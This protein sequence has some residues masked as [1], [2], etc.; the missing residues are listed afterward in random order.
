[1]QHLDEGLLMALLDGELT[2]V[3]QQN[4]ETHLRA[5]SECAGR[6]T[7]LK[8]FMV[9]AD[10]LVADLGEP[11]VI[12][13]RKAR[14]VLARRPPRRRLT[15]RTLAWA[16]SIVGALGLGFAGAQWLGVGTASSDYAVG[17][18]EMLDTASPTVAL[19]P[20]AAASPEVALREE[21]SSQPVGAG[22]A[23]GRGPVEELSE[24]L[25][26]RPN[27][28]VA[29]E[30]ANRSLDQDAGD[31]AAARDTPSPAAQTAA[32]VADLARADLGRA[33]ESRAEQ[34]LSPAAPANA[35]GFR[36]ER[37]PVPVF[38]PVTMEEAVRHLEGVIRLIDGL[39]PEEFE[40]AASDSAQSLVRVVYRVGPAESRLVLEQRRSD[41]SFVASDLQSREQSVDQLSQVNRLSW[42]DLRGFALTLWG[43]ITSD[44]LFHFKTLVK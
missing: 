22:A 26:V 32:K 29:S 38:R 25:T 13:D 2:G 41:N 20:T 39:T 42:N 31:V 17:A 15:P 43:P 40:V 27:T 1:M 19:P 24:A 5:C 18:A 23:S 9:E 8:G 16:A 12:D 28:E 36:R 37:S 4:A 11:P 14:E 21:R 35:A 30:S 7:E 33:P 3:E 44:S 34:R 6:F 10:E